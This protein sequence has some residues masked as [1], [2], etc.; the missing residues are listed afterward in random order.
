MIEATNMHRMLYVIKDSNGNIA[1][2]DETKEELIFKTKEDAWEYVSE[3]SEDD[4]DYIYEFD[5][6]E[7]DLTDMAGS[8]YDGGWRAMNKSDLMAEYGQTIG[9]LLAE[10]LAGIE[11]EVI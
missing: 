1:Y 5:V 6:V 8:M 2:D 9:Q 10:A 7:L 11:E 4:Q 3:K